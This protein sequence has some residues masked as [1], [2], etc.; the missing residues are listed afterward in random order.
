MTAM[1]AAIFTPRLIHQE[2]TAVVV[3]IAVVEVEFVPSLRGSEG[4]YLRAV[5]V[6]RS[7]FLNRSL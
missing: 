6:Y 5:R 1:T 3:M 2:P 4:A 7:N